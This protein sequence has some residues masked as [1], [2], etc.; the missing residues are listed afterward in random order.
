MDV[1]NESI[2]TLLLMAVLGQESARRCA[3]M[4]LKRRG[5][6]VI[7]GEDEDD[8]YMTNLSGVC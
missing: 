4:E 3:R 7:G 2:E 1:R 8:L 6:M 5:A